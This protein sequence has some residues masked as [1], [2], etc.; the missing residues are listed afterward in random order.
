[1]FSQFELRTSGDPASVAG[2]VRRAVRDVLKNVPVQRV[3]TLADQVDASIVPERLIATLSGLFGA[4]GAL[5]AAIGLYGLL[6][7][8]VARRTNEIG[9]RMALGATRGAMSRMVLEDALAMCGAGLAIGAPLAY[10]GQRLAANLIPG[11]SPSGAVPIVVGAATMIALALLAAYLP[12]RRA[13]RV[14]PAEALRYE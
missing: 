9:V 7:Y 12:T 1:M 8:S 4:L 11:L 14:D 2:E 6:A 3:I 13:T 5:I 10:W